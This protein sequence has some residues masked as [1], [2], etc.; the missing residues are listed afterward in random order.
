MVRLRSNKC[1][2]NRLYY[3]MSTIKFL[4]NESRHY[5]SQKLANLELNIF[6]K[7]KFGANLS[8]KFRISNSL[9]R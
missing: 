4:W 2:Y 8:L 5:F 1:I 6:L 9:M 7:S 3:K